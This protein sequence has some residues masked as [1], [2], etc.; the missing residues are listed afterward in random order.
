MFFGAQLR[1][2]RL[3]A[4]WSLRDLAGAVHYSKSHLS[5][6]ET[7]SKTPSVDL[8]RRCD[9]VLGCGGE[10]AQL[11]ASPAV[12]ASSRAAVAADEIWLLVLDPNGGSRF[13]TTSRDD[14]RLR[15]FA[16][17]GAAP[18]TGRVDEST[19]AAFRVMFDEMR[20]LGQS[21]SAVALMPTLVS[22]TQLLQTVAAGTRDQSLRDA[23]LVLAARFAEFA[24]W[25]AQE[26][27]NNDDAERWTDRAVELAA[28]GSDHEMAAYA[29]VRRALITLYN[30]DAVSTIALARRAQSAAS[31]ART[32]GLAAQREAQGHAI[33][34]DYDACFR[35]LEV[36][37]GLLRPTANADSGPVLG[38]SNVTDPV[39][40]AT[41]W[42]LFDLGQP[43]QAV[44]ILRRE[45]EL[46]PAYAR[47][48]RSRFGARL[49]LALA[50]SG[51]VVE[52]CAVAEQALGDNDD[53]DSATIRVDLSALSR[54]LNRWHTQPDVRRVMPRLNEALHSAPAV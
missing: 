34:G 54:T 19:L 43:A 4:G 36:A 53:V 11:V 25:M 12:A 29:L 16:P 6:I 23:A 17:S 35:A 31:S 1:R 45:L 28:A 37:A 41:G 42:C 24:G 26:D 40:M 44:E 18:S 51:E 7:G 10:L 52:A 47:R 38:T 2:R 27:G 5:K 22:Q 32:R 50:G 48:A 39:G 14:T 13:V 15:G 33:A 20:K 3:A 49:A 9:V 8:A 30:Y 46:I 21:M